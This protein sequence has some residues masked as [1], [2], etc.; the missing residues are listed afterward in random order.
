VAVFP[1]VLV[2]WVLVGLMAFGPAAFL[3][4]FMTRKSREHWSIR[5]DDSYRPSLSII[6]P[7]YNESEIILLKLANLI[8]VQYPRNL[9][10][11]LLV[12]SDSTDGTVD[13]A[14]A[15]MEKNKEISFRVL[16]EKERKGKSHALNYALGFCA[17]DMIVVSDADCFWPP[18]ILEKSIPF[19]ADPMVGAIS[20]PKVLLNSDQTWVTRIEG[21]YLASANA[22]RL[23]E[24]KAGSTVFFEG[25]FSA[26]KKEAFDRFDPYGTG[27]DDCGTVV[28]VIENN[29]RTILVPE[30]VFYSPFPTSFRGKIDIKLRRANQLVRV[31][32]RYL[33]S[34]AKGKVKTSKKTVIPNILLYLFSPIIFVVFAFLTV[35]LFS[36]FPVLLIIFASLIISRIRFYFYEIFESNIILFVAICGAVGGKKF[37]I[38]SQPEDR[39]WL[40]KETLSKFNLV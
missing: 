3:F 9:L 14:K 23:G 2:V 5:I 10:E 24:S 31:F 15:F 19:L 11:I 17:G 12:D 32:A 20:G 30:A 8:R 26:F 38:W 37:S 18:G 29:F 34:L 16:V 13:I 27:S 6:V 33:T 21:S 28:H 39:L 35:L 4:V 36:S 1:V 22:L 25:G 7:T 40:T